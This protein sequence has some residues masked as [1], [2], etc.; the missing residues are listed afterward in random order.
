MLKTLCNHVL[1]YTP[2][3]TWLND[4]KLFET[5]S[6]C[7]P[8]QISNYMQ[9]DNLRSM[10]IEPRHNKT[11]KMSV[12]PAKIQISLG[13]HPVSSEYSLSAWRKLR[14]LAT[15]WAHSEDSDQTGRMPR[16]IWV[17]AGRTLVKPTAVK[18][19]RH[20]VLT[21]LLLLVAIATRQ[22]WRHGTIC[23]LCSWDYH[24]AY[25]C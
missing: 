4:L 10:I 13:I 22:L 14:S 17:F 8:F 19:S 2:L 21:F 12:R 15:H 1:V 23:T 6:S 7:W 20:Q 5:N 11:N 18:L 9:H 3:N 25:Q 24:A 16:P